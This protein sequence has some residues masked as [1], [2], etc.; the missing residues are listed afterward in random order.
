M[1]VD[2][3]EAASA[4]ENAASLSR[5]LIKSSDHFQIV[6]TNFAMATAAR[7]TTASTTAIIAVIGFNKAALKATIMPLAAVAIVVPTPLIAVFA[8]VFAAAPAPAPEGLIGTMR[9]TALG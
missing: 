7:A 5:V 3:F 4:P 8:A 6:A 2:A 1:F 9:L